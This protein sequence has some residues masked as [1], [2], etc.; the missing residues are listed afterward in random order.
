MMPTNSERADLATI[1]N[2]IT[3]L[4]L[5]AVPLVAWLRLDGRWAGAF[6]LFVLAGLSDAVDGIIARWFNQGSALGAW[7]D[8]I[9]D[10]ALL[11]AAFVI[12]AMTGLVPVWLVVLAVVRD[13]FILT[14]VAVAQASGK[15]LTIRPMMVSKATTAFQIGLIAIVM[16]AR[17]FDLD[18]AGWRDLLIWGTAALTIASFAT[19]GVVFVRHMSAGGYSR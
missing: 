18:L 4:R 1:P 19:Y 6:W 2:L 15:A 13:A 5:G 8:P 14:G 10:K 16:A 7:L 11:V 9:A 12:L 17:A 3:V